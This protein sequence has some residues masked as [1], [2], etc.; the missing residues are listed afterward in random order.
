MGSL[1]QGAASPADPAT[2][3]SCLPDSTAVHMYDGTKLAEL[4]PFWDFGS[5][6]PNSRQYCAKT[7]VSTYVE[8]YM[9]G[10][11]QPG[12]DVVW[13]HSRLVDFSGDFLHPASTFLR[14]RTRCLA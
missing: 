8:L 12:A 2:T 11:E 10:T 7:E 13:A 9:E 5:Y 14:L 6:M 4:L 1:L 3:L